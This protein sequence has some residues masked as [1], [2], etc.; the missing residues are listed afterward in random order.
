MY[1]P[2]DA[3]HV[4]RPQVKQLLDML[5]ALFDLRTALEAEVFSWLFR[6]PLIS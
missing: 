5:A 6:N 4:A 2:A 3:L 1:L